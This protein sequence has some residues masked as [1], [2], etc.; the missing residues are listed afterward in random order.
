MWAKQVTVGLNSSIL[1]PEGSAMR[2]DW[3][4]VPAT[5]T[6]MACYSAWKAAQR[7]VMAKP[8]C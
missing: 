1:C 4:S 8:S 2:S 7:C 6:L 3:F 5:K